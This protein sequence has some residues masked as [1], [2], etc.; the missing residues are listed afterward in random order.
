ARPAETTTTKTSEEEQPEDVGAVDGWSF[1]KGHLLSFI[2]LFL[3]SI[4]LYFRPYE[5]VPSLSQ[6]TQMAFF[7][8][9]LT[10][11]I[12]FPSQFVLEGNLTARPR[13]INL[14]LLFCLAAF[15]SMP[16]ATSPG[17]S[18]TEFTN[19]LLKAIV[20]FI[21]LV[22]A[23]RTENRLKLLIWLVFAV[24]LYLSVYAISDY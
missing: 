18:Y 23:I 15:L 9:V 7:F 10:L 20:I 11:S 6:Y 17:E 24:S 14:I 12:Y 8:G 4:V 19:V 22:N 13:E 16:L 5:L 21:V 1:R 2:A 3:F